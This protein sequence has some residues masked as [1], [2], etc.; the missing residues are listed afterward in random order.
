MPSASCTPRSSW[1][2]SRSTRRSAFGQGGTASLPPN[3]GDNGSLPPRHPGDRHR[4]DR[5]RRRDRRAGHARLRVQPVREAPA[6]T[7][8]WRRGAPS[9]DLPL[10]AP[11]HRGARRDDRRL[12]ASCRSTTSR[13]RSRRRCSPRARSS[14]CSPGSPSAR[15]SRTS[16]RACS[17]P[18][19]SRSASAT[20]SRSTVRRGSSR[21]WR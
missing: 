1:R 11:R 20:G 15:R 9:H 8:S 4:G 5:P 21:R 7:R 2:T 16:A 18:S 6:A 10:R 17:S 13:R 14:P 19:R 3:P 12:R